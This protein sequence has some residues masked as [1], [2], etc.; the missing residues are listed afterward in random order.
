MPETTTTTAT[1]AAPASPAEPQAN[2]VAPTAQATAAV[3]PAPKKPGVDWAKTLG[4]AQKLVVAQD[5][6]K[7]AKPKAERFDALAA[8]AKEDP[9]AVLE[10]LGLDYNA[11]AV[12]E[13]KRKGLP[14]PKPAEPAAGQPSADAKALETKLSDVT[15]R[16][17]DADAR[18]KEEEE[19]EYQRQ[20][21][22]YASNVDA[23]IQ[24]KAAEFP[25]I[26]ALKATHLVLQQIDARFKK[27][28]TVLT[29]EEAAKEIE[30]QL[31]KE[32]AEAR[33][34]NPALDALFGAPAPAGKVKEPSGVKRRPVVVA[35]PVDAGAKPPPPKREPG[36]GH[37]P[38]K[39]FLEFMDEKTRA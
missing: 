29:G 13:I 2:G 28:G 17:D 34:T 8:K 27:D 15:K 6:L 16:L 19:K 20:W 22:E 32:I 5:E 3:K 26:V 7:V 39:S 37:K 24:T 1:Q 35:P 30:T 18:Q 23:E 11:I 14:P 12:A 10:E 36:G 33:K 21:K 38:K 9:L 31:Q 25:A 4:A